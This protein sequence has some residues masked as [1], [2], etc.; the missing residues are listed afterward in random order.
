M[1]R[2]GE[3]RVDV[4][5]DAEVITIQDFGQFQGVNQQGKREINPEILKK[6]IQDA[7]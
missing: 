3:S 5:A 7:N 4:P 6:V 1:R 2:D